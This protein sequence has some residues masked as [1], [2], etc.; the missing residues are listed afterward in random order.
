[1][2]Y[3]ELMGFG[4]RGWG[5]P[6]LR[7]TLM[8]VAVSVSAFLIGAVFGILG[9][10][11]KL[12]RSLVARSVADAYTTVLR[13]VPDLLVIYLF[14]FGGS[15]ILSAIGRAFGAQGFV[16]MPAFLTGAIAVGIVSGAFQTEVYRG[17]YLAIAKGELEAAKAV[18]MHRFTMLRRIIAPQ[19]LRFAIPG[20]GNVWQLVLKE[21]AL[22]SV[23][24]LVELLRQSQIGS[25]STRQPFAFF[26]TAAAL[27]LVL[28]TISTWGFRQAEEHAMRGVRRA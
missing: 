10:W 14:Y 3:F 6:M 21:S 4:P 16:G 11:A 25:G 24:G 17:A 8:T 13:G 2:S 9:A 5:E 20:L 22:I 1:M 19:V 26:L 18:G 12:S 27:Y 23:T 15:A 7:A 28:T